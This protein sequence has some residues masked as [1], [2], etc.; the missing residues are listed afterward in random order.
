[1][2][3]RRDAFLRHNLWLMAFTAFALRVAVMWLRHSY[4]F[5]AAQ[6]HYLFGTEMGRV[7]RSLVSGRGFA[8]PLHGQT[9]P[10]AMVGPIYPLLIAA[11]FKLLG[12]YSVAS[13]IALLTL[14]ALFSALTAPAVFF[15]GRMAFDARTGT[16]AGWGWVFFPFAIYWPV[17]WVWDTSLSAL[18]FALVFAATLRLTRSMTAIEAVLYGV[19]WGLAVL[20]NTTFLP[21][22]PLLLGWVCHQRS[23]LGTRWVRP[24]AAAALAFGLTLTPWLVRN[25]FAFGHVLLRSN[26]GLELVL[27]NSPGASTP[28]EW[29]QLHPSVN[30]T[31]MAQYRALGELRYMA[32]KQRE[33]LTFITEHPDIFVRTTAMRVLYFWFDVESLDRIVHFPEVLFGIPAIFAFAGLWLAVVRRQSAAFPFA[34]VFLIFP[35]V[36]YVTHPDARF[37]HLIEP[38]VLVLGAYGGLA[39][40]RRLRGSFP[41]PTPRPPAGVGIA[42]SGCTL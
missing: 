3:M 9:G 32:A 29:Q 20:T 4:R 34:A 38:E 11:M 18:L 26:L 42:D 21:L 5:P 37:R 19:L 39:A 35:L 33:A 22:L 25:Y 12:L 16:W 23:R 14:N 27:G 36:Y 31:E 10:T 28:R 2:A 30:P 7:A 8:S 17:V 1:M 24:A 6:N 15:I 41:P 13:A 40:W